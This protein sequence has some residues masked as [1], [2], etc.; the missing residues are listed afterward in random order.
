M[1]KIVLVYLLINPFNRYSVPTLAFSSFRYL[2]YAKRECLVSI[3]HKL[4]LSV[5]EKRKLFC[6][7]PEINILKTR[8]H[9]QGCPLLWTGAAGLNWPSD[10]LVCEESASTHCVP[11]RRV[12]A[13]APAPLLRVDI[14]DSANLEIFEFSSSVEY[15]VTYFYTFPGESR[16]TFSGEPP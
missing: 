14:S 1:F 16:G 7:V 12:P 10:L 8:L 15:R 13:R 6:N 11:C 9:S 3:I 5:F 2:L 4:V